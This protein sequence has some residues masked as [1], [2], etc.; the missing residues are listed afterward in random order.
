MAAQRRL[1]SDLRSEVDV[2]D[3]GILS[4][5]VHEDPFL[6]LTV[7]AFD[8]GQELTEHSSSRPAVIEILEGHAEIVLDGTTGEVG[9]GTWIAL[10]PGTRHAIRAVSPLKM[11]LMLIRTAAA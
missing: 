11:A 1:I 6:S 8:A 7:F 4:R 2:P 10:A 9:P 5:T 3:G